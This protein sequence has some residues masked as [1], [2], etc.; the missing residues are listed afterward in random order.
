MP[1]KCTISFGARVN[2]ADT[3]DKK[4]LILGVDPGLITT[5]YGLIEVVN[6]APVMIEG[7]VIRIPT[8]LPL[9]KRLSTIF[10][11]IQEII[12]EF[13]PLS[14]ALEEVHTQYERPRVTVMMGHARGVIC[15]AAAVNQVP[16]MSYAPT[17][18][19][20]ALTGNGRAGKEQIRRMIELRLNLK[21]IPEPYDVSDALAVALCHIS[22]SGRGIE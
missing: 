17:Q 18:I 11:G 9:E 16:V 12:L 8:T 2:T 21:T 15:L 1:N 6:N 4:H 14:L 22:R 7:G 3:R 5:G 10:H 20:S 19:K 13:K